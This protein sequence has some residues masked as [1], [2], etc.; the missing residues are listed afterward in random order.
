[1][2]MA[3]K[4]T[5]TDEMIM[6]RMP[7][8]PLVGAQ[9]LERMKFFR[10]AERMRGKPS[11]KMK[12]VMRAREPMEDRARSKQSPLD[13]FLPVHHF[14]P[15][16]PSDSRIFWPLG[17]RTK[18]RK[19]LQEPPGSVR[20]TRQKTAH[21]L[22]GMGFNVFP[23]GQDAVDGQGLDPLIHQP[24][25][26]VAQRIGVAGDNLPHRAVGILDQ[27]RGGDFLLAHDQVLEGLP[28]AGAFFPGNQ[29]DVMGRQS[30]GTPVFHGPAEDL[31]NLRQADRGQG[32]AGVDD[33]R[34]AVISDGNLY[35]FLFFA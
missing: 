29:V 18:S 35:E 24:G 15:T 23:G 19:A 13:E 11:M 34:N 22:I 5:S 3:P 7:K 4:V 8:W 32:I 25:G 1:M 6:A 20:L 16:R 21:Q 17:P 31:P 28:G 2:T 12:M 30:Q 27:R 14:T 10:P 9:W 33:D 26:D